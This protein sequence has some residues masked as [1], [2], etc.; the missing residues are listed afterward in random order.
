M[1]QELG[2][3]RHTNVPVTRTL[4]APAVAGR[5]GGGWMG[6]TGEVFVEL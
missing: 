4:F 6:R 3:R 2:C 5:G 1:W